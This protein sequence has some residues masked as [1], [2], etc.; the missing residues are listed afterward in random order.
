[1]GLIRDR[2]VPAVEPIRTISVALEDGILTARRN[3]T[4]EAGSIPHA[5]A[6]K[7]TLAWVSGITDN[8]SKVV[9]GSALLDFILDWVN[10]EPIE[11][12]SSTFNVEETKDGV[13]DD[14]PEV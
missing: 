13:S 14:V 11:P 7:L 3:T 8:M 10:S 12:L 6:G 4:E 2:D 1:M 9:V 5:D